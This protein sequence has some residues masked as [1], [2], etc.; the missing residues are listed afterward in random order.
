MPSAGHQPVA[1]SL[2]VVVP[3]YNEIV[4]AETCVRR[5]LEALKTMPIASELIQAEEPIV[6]AEFDQDSIVSPGLNTRDF[7]LKEARKRR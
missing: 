1:T 3:M 2:A 6:F 7:D 4:G 5:I